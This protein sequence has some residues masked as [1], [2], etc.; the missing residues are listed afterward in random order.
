MTILYT[1]HY[2]E[3]AENLCDDIAIIDHGKILARGAVPELLRAHRA[4]TIV[5]HLDTD[6][7]D[8]VTQQLRAL[9]QLRAS[10]FEARSIEVESDTPDATLVAM[11]EILRGARLPLVSLSLGAM[12]LE[13]VFLALTG[14]RL[15]D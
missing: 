14:T 10:R 12:N 8:A 6:L 4:G 13:Q 11:T 1:T 7:P 15:R 5:A 2:M 3:E 9:P